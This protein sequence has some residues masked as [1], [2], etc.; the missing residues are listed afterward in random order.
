MK[1]L[2]VYYCTGGISELESQINLEQKPVA[3]YSTGVVWQ[4]LFFHLFSVSHNF[5][6]I[7]Q[8]LLPAGTVPGRYQL[9]IVLYLT[10]R[11]LPAC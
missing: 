7:T 9:F 11:Y 6:F 4:G 3:R 1:V 2:V 5:L 8:K 10:C